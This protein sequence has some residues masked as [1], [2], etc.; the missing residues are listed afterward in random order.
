MVKWKKQKFAFASTKTVFDYVTEH[1]TDEDYRPREVSRAT[2]CMP[3]SPE[4]IDVLSAR[5]QRGEELWHRKDRT[6]DDVIQ[7]LADAADLLGNNNDGN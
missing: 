4:K 5:V 3:G 7:K 6:I 1:S 2:S